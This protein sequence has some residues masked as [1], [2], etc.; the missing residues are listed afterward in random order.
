MSLSDFILEIPGALDASVCK[1]I[2]EKF[3]ADPR[4][5]PGVMTGGLNPDY[6]RS[7]DLHVTDLTDWADLDRELYDSLGRGIR[8]YHDQ[9]PHLNEFRMKDLGYQ[10]QRSEPGEFY[11]WHT[12]V[13]VLR[14]A[15]RQYVFIWYL[16]D[17]VE[18]G[19][20][21]LKYQGRRVKP[22]QGKLLL[23]PATW[24]HYHRGEP[25]VSNTK[26]IVTGWMVLY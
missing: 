18:G 20:T 6:K 12:D 2:I 23:F 17:V 4:K 19:H 13:S 10:I 14:N 21:E 15:A 25:V 3:E 9:Y 16:N 11:H 22:E 1:R 7:T 8:A 26:Y 5:A 24:T